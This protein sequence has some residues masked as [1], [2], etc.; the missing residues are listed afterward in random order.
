MNQELR[1]DLS[2]LQSFYDD[3]VRAVAAA[4]TEIP[5]LEV[6]AEE[7]H[8]GEDGKVDPAYQLAVLRRSRH[9]RL[10]D[11]RRLAGE[12]IAEYEDRGFPRPGWR[13]DPEDRRPSARLVAEHFGT[14]PVSEWNGNDAA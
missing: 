14:A 12:I 4:D 10:G 13:P 3:A 2:S 6:A 8:R 5:K 7:G 9:V 1:W 11:I